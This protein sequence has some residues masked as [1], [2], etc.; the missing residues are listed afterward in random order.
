[1]KIAITKHEKRLMDAYC[2]YCMDVKGYLPSEY[3]LSKLIDNMNSDHRWLVD[4]YIL[5]Q[6]KKR[7]CLT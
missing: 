3:D 1:M 5:D 6:A 4:E 7:N 2:K